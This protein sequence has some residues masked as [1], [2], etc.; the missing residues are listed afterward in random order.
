MRTVNAPTSVTSVPGNS[1]NKHQ[2]D[3]R[4]CAST[5]RHDSNVFGT[6]HNTTQSDSLNIIYI[7]GDHLCDIY[8]CKPTKHISRGLHD[9]SLEHLANICDRQKRELCQYL[10]SGAI[11]FTP[12]RQEYLSSIEEMHGLSLTKFIK[13][14]VLKQDCITPASSWKSVHQ[15]VDNMMLFTAETSKILGSTSIRHR[16]DGK[17]SDRCLIDAHPN[18][19][20]ICV[21]AV[22]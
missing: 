11:I 15:Y 3:T 2:N 22:Y 21:L 1:G 7:Y 9:A 6:R 5:I 19:L 20:A 13:L 14:T 16:S 12:I 8:A 4:E 18:V 17:I 10:R